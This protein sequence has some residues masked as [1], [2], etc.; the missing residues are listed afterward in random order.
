[1]WPKNPVFPP[2]RPVSMGANSRR[3]EAESSSNGFKPIASRTGNIVCCKAKFS[4]WAG[5]AN[6][7]EWFTARLE[8]AEV[9]D[10]VAEQAAR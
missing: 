1:M 6:R 2:N 3:F 5:A 8:R 7:R 10:P 4:I 9:R